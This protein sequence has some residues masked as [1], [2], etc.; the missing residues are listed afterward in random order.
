MPRI[1]DYIQLDGNCYFDSGYVPSAHTGIG[2]LFQIT[3]V[4]TKQQIVGGVVDSGIF[5]YIPYYVNGSGYGAYFP[6]DLTTGGTQLATANTTALTYLMYNF[7]EEGQTSSTLVRRSDSTNGNISVAIAIDETMENTNDITMWIC[8]NHNSNDTVYGKALVGKFYEFGIYENK[9]P[10]RYYLPALDDN[11]VVCLYDIITKTYIYNIGSGTLAYGNVAYT[12]GDTR[13][14]KLAYL[15]TVGATMVVDYLIK[16]KHSKLIIEFEP[17]FIYP[18]LNLY[19][20]I[21]NP[22]GTNVSRYYI[23]NNTTTGLA[24]CWGP[25]SGATSCGT[26]VKQRMKYTIDG[27]NNKVYREVS[28]S[29]TSYNITASSEP[30][31]TVS[32]CLLGINNSTS[33][34]SDF[35]VRFYSAEIWEDDMLI[36]RF[37]PWRDADGKVCLFD[38][39]T[40][41]NLYTGNVYGVAIAGPDDTNYKKVEYTTT[42][43][44]SH[45]GRGRSVIDDRMY[46][47]RGDTGGTTTIIDRTMTTL[48]PDIGTLTSISFASLPTKLEYVSGEDIDLTGIK[49]VGLYSSGTVAD[50]TSLCTCIVPS[51]LVSSGTAVVTYDTFTL[52]FD[53][54]ILVPA[55]QSTITLCHFDGNCVDEVSGN[56]MGTFSNAVG[57]YKQGHVNGGW[58]SIANSYAN[59]TW[60]NLKNGTFTIEWWAKN[61]SSTYTTTFSQK[62]VYY[63]GSTTDT[64]GIYAN[65]TVTQGFAYD[66]NLLHKDAL[67]T[68]AFGL[69]SNCSTDV[70]NYYIDSNFNLYT[71]WHHFAIVITNGFYTCYLDGHKSSAGT[72]KNFSGYNERNP[73]RFGLGSNT[74]I[75]ELL[76]CTEVKYVGDFIPDGPYTITN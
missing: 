71:S 32:M 37:I 31:S 26:I 41:T 42:K 8:A 44:I 2:A 74:I 15:K 73:L 66:R 34:S 12:L 28:G 59:Y 52:T 60:A 30:D 47:M 33:A 72:C 1:L 9:V 27:V 64:G 14:T 48:P 69:S 56:S 50:I 46:T 63:D 18:Y 75:D 6:V 24:Y 76:I 17:E 23:Q 57:K 70:T 54:L 11:N 40:H 20:A 25:T 21:D 51:P 61:N 68:H 35:F 22:G 10:V 16:H 53:Y 4:S 3:S 13:D 62:S 43:T 67:D 38:E 5:R 19:G 36:H 58:L 65:G 29:T 39:V 49:V 7:S 45:E 55:P